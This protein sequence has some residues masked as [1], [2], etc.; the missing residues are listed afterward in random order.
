ML[1]CFCWMCKYANMLAIQF[2]YGHNLVAVILPR[3]VKTQIREAFSH[4]KSQ[5]YRLII[6]YHS[7]IR[8]R[9]NNP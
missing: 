2:L 9:L 6:T 5:Y 1:L 3:K 4:A 7:C 8:I